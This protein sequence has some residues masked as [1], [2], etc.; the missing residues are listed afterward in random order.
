MNERDILENAY[1]DASKL[2]T[3]S[4]PIIVKKDIAIL[5]ANIENNK[6]LVSALTTS[7]LKKIIS[8][9]QD[10]RLHRTDFANGYSA[11][12]LDTHMTS[13]FFKDNFP[14][15]ANK[16]SAFLTLATREKIK[17]TKKDGKSLK[18]RNTKLKEAFLNI[19]DQIEIF[20]QDPKRYLVYLFFSLREIS[21]T[22]EALFRRTE[23]YKTENV[24]N[25]NINTI[26]SMLSQHFKIKKSS[27]LPV[28]AI[29][30]I[31]EVLFGKFDR[32]K[33]KKLVPLQAHTSS[34]KHSFGDIEIYT[35]EGRPFEIVEIKHNIPIDKYLIFDVIKKIS[36]VKVD[37]YYI[38]TTFRNSF[39]N[40][41]EEKKIADIVLKIKRERSVDIIANGI[42]TTLKYYLRFINNYEDFLR[43]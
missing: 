26:L 3:D 11:R 30:S 7:L 17:W 29:Y 28:I 22:N 42:L 8:P 38:L 36:N 5:I 13:P 10:I 23:V 41:A 40:A 9:K 27:R 2:N 24:G 34:D 15:Y 35:K 32:Y 12:V 18:I 4:I 31:Y 19:L 39:K 43:C 37:R 1:K 25:L 16:E 6:S 33:D 21:K 14:K 20:K